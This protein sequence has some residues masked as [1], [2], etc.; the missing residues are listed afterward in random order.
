VQNIVMELA[1]LGKQGRERLAL[2]LRETEV[3]VS[4]AEVSKILGVTRQAA[5]RILAGFAKNG[6]LSRIATG[7]YIPVELE[8][9]DPIPIP[10]EPFAIA[11]KLFSP[12]YISGWSAAEYWGL[13][14]QI[15]QSV[16][17]MTLKPQKNYRPEINGAQYVLH[18]TKLNLFFG[19]KSIWIDGVKVQISDVTRTV[20]DIVNKPELAGGVRVAVD[21]LKNYM[22]SKEKN[23]LQMDSYL[24]KMGKG[25][26]Y[27]RMGY[28]IE[29]YYPEEEQFIAMCISKLSSGYSKLDLALDCNKLV[30]KWRLM[31]PESWKK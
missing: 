19:L 1:G 15:F 26:A 27:K 30:T 21:I 18:L 10:E 29:K 20:L 16:I 28:L 31:V 23:L 7:I 5:A 24:E 12:C 11:Q 22:G 8:A 6:W 13:T 17:V 25:V 14:E 4:I 3:T 2:I 9:E